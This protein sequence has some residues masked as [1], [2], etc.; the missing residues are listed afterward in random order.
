MMWGLDGRK[1]CISASLCGALCFGLLS[2]SFFAFKESMA[3][4][5]AVGG[6]DSGVFCLDSFPPFSGLRSK[7]YGEKGSNDGQREMGKESG[8]S[9]SMSNLALVHRVDWRT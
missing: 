7:G 1:I 6:G 5:A 3:C 8:G 2:L 9:L 4:I